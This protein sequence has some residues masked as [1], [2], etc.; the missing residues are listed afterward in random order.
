MNKYLMAISIG[1]VQDFIASARRSRD[2]WFG[3]WLLSELSKAAAKHIADAPGCKLIFP[4]PVN[5]TDDLQPNSVFSVVN[6][7]LAEIATDDIQNFG[8]A[9]ENSIRAAI[10][11]RL[12]IIRQTAFRELK[13]DKQATIYWD[14][15]DAQLNDLVE[16]Y[17]AACPFDGVNYA[18]TRKKTEA[19]LAA[20]KATRNF[21]SAKDW[22]GNAPK[23]ALDGQRESVIDEDVFDQFKAAVTDE[24]QRR[25]RLRYGVRGQER[26]CGVGLLK[27]H[28]KPKEQGV[29]NFYSTSHIA[30]LPL[31][32]RLQ[33]GDDVQTYLE[34]LKTALDIDESQVRRELGHVHPQATLKPHEYFGHQD[35][36]RYDGRLLF[37][38]RFRE[39]FTEKSTQKEKVKEATKA[40]NHFLATLKA[41]GCPEVTAPTPYYAILH[42]DGDYMGAAIDEQA[43]AG[44]EQHRAISQALSKFAGQVKRLVEK[45]YEGCCI[46]AGG[47]DV[48]ALLPLHTALQCA[49]KLADEF[50]TALKT[51]EFNENG[52][53]K[54]PTLSVGLAVGH[55]LNPLQE[56]LEL[57][58]EAEKIAKKVTGKNAL[59][60]TV[61]KRSGAARTV[62]DTWACE[63]LRGALDARLL[64]F[65]YLYLADELPDGAAYE[66]R[67]LTLRLKPPSVAPELTQAELDKLKAELLAA[68]Q[69]EAKRILRRKQPQHG[70]KKTLAQ[71]VLDELGGFIDQTDGQDWTLENLA[72]ELI[73][74]RDFA[75]AMTQAGFTRQKFADKNKLKLLAQEETDNGDK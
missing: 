65:I 31:L 34:A 63:S 33:S 30:A 58:R 55:H 37:A 48:L 10:A 61:N 59:A 35:G 21:I 39:L 72:D 74:A 22:A 19:L 27:R 52:V 49:R 1:P 23:S 57:A 67:D 11:E 42:A 51:F 43:Q 41:E 29:D 6:K 71:Q 69:A 66:L 44:P 75:N 14:N 60:V 16:F 4:A 7:I 17:W 3:S 70:A 15:A 5:L 9:S 2:L 18:A 25:L 32:K 13:K 38:D 62:K 24:Q 28:G 53:K 20:R 56:T 47:D 40:L 64:R 46:Y 73:I 54:S 36:T 26:L 50:H 8:E 45:E 68:Q 12:N